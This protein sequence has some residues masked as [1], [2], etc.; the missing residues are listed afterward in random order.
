[1]TSSHEKL[2]WLAHEIGRPTAQLVVPGEGT[3]SARSTTPGR[4]LT[5]AAGGFLDRIDEGDTTECEARKLEGL[6]EMPLLDSKTNLLAETQLDP[7]ARLPAQDAVLHAWLLGLDGV[8][9][10]AQVHPTSCLQVLCS[11]GAERFSDHRL[12]PSEIMAFG[13]QATYVPYSEPGIPLAREIRSKVML[14]QRRNQGQNPRLVLVQNYGL[15]AMG[16]TAEATL[17]VALVAEKAAAVFVGS[18]RL[19]AQFLP[20]QQIVRIEMRIADNTRPS[21]IKP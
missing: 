7:A 21:L 17:R 9:F 13:A 15:V 1:M 5:T 11:Q 10:V 18:S 20:T 16:A 4:I 2:L 6:F 3:V 14:T 12:F 19:G 8:N